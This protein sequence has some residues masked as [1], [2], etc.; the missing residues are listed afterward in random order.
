MSQ[1]IV[2]AI[3]ANGYFVGASVADESPLEPGEYLIPG[4][5]VDA[6]PPR[7]P[8]G[9]RARWVSGAWVFES[10][11]APEPV[12]PTPEELQAA[13][14]DAVQDRLDA[15][16]RERRYDSILSACTYATSTVPRFAAEGQHAV[17]M[18]DAT[19]AALYLVQADA[20][21]GVLSVASYADV[22]PLLPVLDWSVL[23]APAVS[24]LPN[25]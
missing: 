1:K 3:D 17:A 22:E 2:A 18:R 5:S 14:V 12:P 16:A 10:T 13:I 11:T 20:Q 7:E 21:A 9:T 25:G 8:D 4:G 24:E 6:P 19:W 23:D 15:F